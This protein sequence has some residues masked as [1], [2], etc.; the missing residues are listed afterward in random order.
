MGDPEII[1][2]LRDSVANFLEGH[3]DPSCKEAGPGELKALNGELWGE[4]AELGWLALALPEA[5]GG[6]G[7]GLREATVLTEL[8]GKYAFDAPYIAAVVIPSVIIEASD[9]GFAGE[10]APRLV[11]GES[12]FS[13]AWQESAGEIEFADTRCRVLDDGRVEGKKFFVPAVES[14]TVLLV[15]AKAGD[16]LVVVAVSAGADGVGKQLSS[17][18]LGPVAEITLDRVKVLGNGPLLRGKKAELAL[19]QSLAAGRIALAAQLA[20]LASGCLSKTIAYT[21][22]R[23]QFGKP[24]GSMQS[25]RH[26]CVDMHIAI[27]LADASWRQALGAMESAPDRTET[28]AAI[29]AAKA[30]CADTAMHVARGSVQLHGAM[31]FTEEGGIG[32]YLRAAMAGSGWLGSPTAHRR[33]FLSARGLLRH[34]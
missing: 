12:L 34:A 23:V 6:S 5:L 31:G 3:R 14:N 30:R 4:M 7:L 27:L 29:S 28:L 32:R 25:V 20:G 22:D 9:N 26:R 24:L 8:F 2:M 18:A 19:S 15:T 10:L 17:T 33:R 13:L 1:E 21:S 16:E 11:S